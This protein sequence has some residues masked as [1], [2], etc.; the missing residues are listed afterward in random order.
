VQYAVIEIGRQA[1]LRY[2]WDT[3]AR[4]AGGL[5]RRWINPEIKE[6]PFQRAMKEILSPLK[7]SYEIRDGTTIVLTKP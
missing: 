5:C 3:S 1:G 7:L 2:D 6:Q 4:N